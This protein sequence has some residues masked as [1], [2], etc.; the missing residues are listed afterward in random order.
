MTKIQRTYSVALIWIVLGWGHSISV[1]AQTPV[2]AQLTASQVSTLASPMAG[3][4]KKVTVKTGQSVKKG[5]L[6]I[7]FDCRAL[8]AERSIADA[9]LSAAQTQHQVNQELAEFENIS[10][11]EVKLSQAAVAEAQANRQLAALRV[12][13]CKILAPFPAEVVSIE[14]HSHEF[15]AAGD[16][17]MELVNPHSLEVEW[18]MPAHFLQRI[19]LKSEIMFQSD[20]DGQPIIA[21]VSRIVDS[22]DPVSQTVKVM[23]EPLGKLTKDAIPGISGEVSLSEKMAV[24]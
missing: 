2:R 14:V 18:V 6:L 22:V 24:Q 16:P 15:A 7:E 21:R 4:V 11:L 1:T 13:D 17:M 5:E 3:L 19:Q 8:K 12:Q 9:R 10:Q 23:A 20:S